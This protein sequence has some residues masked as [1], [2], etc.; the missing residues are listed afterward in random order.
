ME[1]RQ[2]AVGDSKYCQKC[3]ACRTQVCCDTLQELQQM[4]SGVDGRVFKTCKKCRD[5]KASK[6]EGEALKPSGFDLDGCYDTHEEL[7]EAMS[8]FLEQHDSHVFDSSLPSLRIRA[9][10]KST[11]LID[12]DISVETCTKSSHQGVQKRAAVL[13]R[14][15][16]FDCTGYFFHMRRVNARPDGEITFTLTCSRS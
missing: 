9:S 4:Y 11:F 6:K 5:R 14:N 16:M 15:D 3:A 2:V 13:L 8:S 7:V 1:G 12:N 10:L